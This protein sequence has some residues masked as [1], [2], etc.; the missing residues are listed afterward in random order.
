MYCMCIRT[1]VYTY[2]HMYVHTYKWSAWV[3]IAAVLTIYSSSNNTV[4]VSA[5]WI[6]FN[7]HY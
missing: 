7:T 5:I 1:Y 3:P 2:G 6:V 4:Y